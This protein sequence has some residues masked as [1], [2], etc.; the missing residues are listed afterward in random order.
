MNIFYAVDDKYV[1]QLGAAICSVCENNKS[2]DSIHIYVGTKEVT[3]ENQL[4]ITKLVEGYDRQITIIQID[5]IKE[6]IGFEFNTTAWNEVTLVR[7]LLDK[8]LPE[9]VGRLLYLDADT[10]VLGSLQ[11]LWDTD[12]QGKAIGASIEPTANHQRKKRLGLDGEPYYNAGVLLIDMERWRK[13]NIRTRIFEYYKTHEDIILAPDQDSI[14]GALAGEIFS[15]SPRYNYF[16]VFWYYPYKTLVKI[17]KPACWP[18]S[19]EQHQSVATDPCI[20]HYLGEDRPWRKGNTHRYSGQYQQYL[21]M[22]PWK[23]TP[24]KEGWSVYFKFYGAYWRV[25]KSFPMLQYRVM[26][27]LIPLVLKYREKKRIKEQCV[28]KNEQS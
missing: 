15:I 7:L 9:N 14:N 28:Q 24:L 26:D 17:Y 8:I 2:I 20:I 25:L 1:P 19:E 6:Q 12:M 18:F 21:S 27:K 10:I 16:N 4:L 11:D 22:T 5:N 3:S 13:D 23:D